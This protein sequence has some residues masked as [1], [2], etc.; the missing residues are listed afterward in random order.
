M[1]NAHLVIFFSPNVAVQGRFCAFLHS[2]QNA[3][4]TCY[5]RGGRFHMRV[6]AWY[7]LTT[8]HHPAQFLKWFYRCFTWFFWVF[9][10]FCFFSSRGFNIL[11]LLVQRQCDTRANARWRV[12]FPVSLRR[13]GVH[14]QHRLVFLWTLTAGGGNSGCSYCP[15]SAGVWEQSWDASHM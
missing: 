15:L 4:C 7:R 11:R 6:E 13:L 2:R 14:F 10:F 5:G 12:C 3:A 9:F 1:K 8:P